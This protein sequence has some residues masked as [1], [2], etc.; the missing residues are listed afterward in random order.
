MIAIY[1]F[2]KKNIELLLNFI[3]TLLVASEAAL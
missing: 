1:F 2:L 3:V